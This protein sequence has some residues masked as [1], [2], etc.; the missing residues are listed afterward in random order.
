MDRTNRADNVIVAQL[1]GC[2]HVN[3]TQRCTLALMCISYLIIHC[4]V[5]SERK[6]VDKQLY[7]DYN[8]CFKAQETR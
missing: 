1:P 7:L 4:H 6:T 2:K 8:F 5:F 3:Q